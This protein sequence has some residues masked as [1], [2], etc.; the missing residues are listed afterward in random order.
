MIMLLWRF[1]LIVV[2]KE[3]VYLCMIFWMGC[4]KLDGL[5]VVSSC[6][7]NLSDDFF[8]I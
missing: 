2:V 5:G 7:R 6:L 4:L 8:M 1:V 3:F